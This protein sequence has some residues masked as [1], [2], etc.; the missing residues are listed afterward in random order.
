MSAVV[1]QLFAGSQEGQLNSGNSSDGGRMGFV[2]RL[3][4]DYEH[5][6][7]IEGEI[8]TEGEMRTGRHTYAYLVFSVYFSVTVYVRIGLSLIHIYTRNKR[9]YILY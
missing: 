7:I 4:Y 6:Y 9:N 2:G 1:D 5:R 8:H 3:K